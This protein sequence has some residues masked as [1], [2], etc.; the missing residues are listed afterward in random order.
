M[1]LFDKLF[2]RGKD[3]P[4]ARS[5]FEA[6]G[7]ICARCGQPIPRENLALDSGSGRPVHRA[8]PEAAS[9]G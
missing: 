7:K 9:E 3:D 5:D 6:D 4:A 8:C 2:Q 1:G